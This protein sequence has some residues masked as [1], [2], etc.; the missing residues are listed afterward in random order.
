MRCYWN[1]HSK[2]MAIFMADRMADRQ[3]I[4]QPKVDH[5]APHFIKDYFEDENRFLSRG[6]LIISRLKFLECGNKASDI[7]KSYNILHIVKA[8][9]KFKCCLYLRRGKNTSNVYKS[10][11]VQVNVCKNWRG[12]KNVCPLKIKL[13]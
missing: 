10:E 9:G 2:S 6:W 13:A 8:S 1:I 4:Q 7:Q 11:T 12:L 3:I 5:L